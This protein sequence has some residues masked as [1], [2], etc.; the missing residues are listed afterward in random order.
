MAGPWSQSLP[1]RCDILSP[2]QQRCSKAALW[3]EALPTEYD[4]P[5][6]LPQGSDLHPGPRLAY[7]CSFLFILQKHPPNKSLA[8]LLL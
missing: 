6:L 3:S 5:R 1:A 4:R 2:A 7:V 8:Y